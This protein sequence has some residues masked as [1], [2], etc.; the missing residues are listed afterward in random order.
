M[1][2]ILFLHQRSHPNAPHIAYFSNWC[3]LRVLCKR[4]DQVI[5]TVDSSVVIQVSSIPIV[6]SFKPHCCCCGSRLRSAHRRFFSDCHIRFRFLAS[7]SC[8]SIFVADQRHLLC[9]IK[10]ADGLNQGLYSPLSMVYTCPSLRPACPQHNGSVCEK[11]L[12]ARLLRI[13]FSAK[14]PHSVCPMLI[15]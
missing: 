8:N 14:P 13:A 9:Q 3:L 12:H 4:P 6:M 2:S 15:V 10:Q 7:L 5:T 1:A 11:H